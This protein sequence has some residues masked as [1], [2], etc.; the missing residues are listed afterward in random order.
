VLVE[1]TILFRNTRWWWD[2]A[3]ISG[4]WT[5]VDLFFVIS[6]FLISGL[7]FSEFQKRG[8][9]NFAR[10]AIRRALK[11]Y[12]T[13]YVLVFWTTLTR[14]IH[15]RFQN[16]GG[17]I[18][19]ALHDIFFVQSYLPGTYGHFWS[20]S[21]E[22]HFYILL[23]LTLY[24]MLRKGRWGD[25]DPFRKLPLT[26]LLVAVLS[27]AGRIVT[28]VLVQ[29][30][31][32]F[33]HLFPTHLR[34]DSLLFG[35]LL[36]YWSLLHRERF[37]AFI[38]R[39]RPLLFPISL[40]LIMPAFISKPDFIVYTVQLSSLYLGYG[41]LMIS[42]LQVPM[43]TKGSYG[44]L[45]RPM[46]Y[47]GQHS[48]PIYVF[49]LMIMG[50]LSKHNLL[51]GARGMALYFACTVGFGILFSKVI[52]FPVLH[53]R[54]RIFPPEVVAEI[55]VGVPRSESAADQRLVASRVDHAT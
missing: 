7:L 32:N 2:R 30:Y 28:A 8:R 17:V 12:P 44:W 3:A 48:Y 42:L 33:T 1:H 4:G 11:L 29:P 54:D 52:E 21:V 23:P 41:G 25:N 13:L 49:H 38:N 14:L 47:I 31:D 18:K 15:A 24:F 50:Q 37:S 39:S 9:I 51:H 22:E 27:L 5:G 35:V 36:S 26:F 45:L 10:F 53:L 34:L 43:T 20:L 55:P 46:S 40:L 19:P 6:G 16:V